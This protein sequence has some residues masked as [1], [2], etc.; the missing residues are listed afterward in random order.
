MECKEVAELIT[1]SLDGQVEVKLRPALEEHL[2]KCRG[3]KLE[4]ELERM[5]KSLTNRLLPRA[6][7]PPQT[8]ARIVQSLAK[9]QAGAPRSAW[10][11]IFSLPIKTTI[12]AMDGAV[13]VFALFMILFP[14]KAPHVHAAAKDGNII[15]QTYNNYDGVVNGSLVP[16]IASDDPVAVKAFLAAKTDFNV[17]VPR[18]NTCTLMGALSSYYDDAC[19]AH[20]IYRHGRDVIY[21]YET[22]VDPLMSGYGCALNLPDEVK[23][24]L[25]NKGW[26]VESHCPDCTL[27]IW[28]PDS[29]TICCAMSEMGS[30]QLMACLK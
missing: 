13:A 23:L 5:T 22:R 10:H 9:E 4:A 25:K 21:V 28:Q 3:C 6:K 11:E 20:V 26:Y 24:Q 15:H 27:M 16:Q 8:A 7:T 30:E 2:T 18:L 29:S 17:N 1:A 12:F 14:A 19:V